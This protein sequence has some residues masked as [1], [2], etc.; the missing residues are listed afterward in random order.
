MISLAIAFPAIDPVIVQLGPLAIRWYAL[1]YVAGILFGWWYLH[2]LTGAARLWGGR[3][4]PTQA[5][6]DDVVVW[7][8]FGVV[9]GGRLGYVLFYNP[10]YYLQHPLEVAAVWTGG[11]S[12]HGG[13]LGVMIALAAFAIRNRLPYL[14]L[15]DAV[16]ATIP[17]GLGLGRLA[18]FINGELFGAPAD[19]PWAV[20]FPLGGPEPRHPSQI[21]EAG[22]EGLVLFTLLAVLIWRGGALRRPGIACGT[23]AFGYAVAR[24]FVEF[25]RTPDAQI[26]Y[27]A[28]GWLT[29]GMVLSLPLLVGGLLMLLFGRQLER[30]PQAAAAG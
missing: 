28:G 18:N 23:F 24:I 22:L 21:Y 8:V 11:M 29:M 19:V 30:P 10:G 27:L 25:Y 5:Q 4:H 3:V 2:R 16:A 17:V 1:S 12:F 9:L 7:I 26:G 15:L 6:A 20:V 13:W 14:S